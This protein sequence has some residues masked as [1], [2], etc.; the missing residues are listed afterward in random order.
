MTAIHQQTF[1]SGLVRVRELEH[2]VQ[3][4]R[5]Y[6][7]AEARLLERGAHIDRVVLDREL[8]S[9]YQRWL[10]ERDKEH[11]DYDGHPIG[12]PM[13]FAS[14]LTNTTCRTSMTRFI[15]RTSA[16]SIRSRMAAGIG[17]TSRSPRSTL[18]APTAPVSRGR[19]SP[20]IGA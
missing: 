13:R 2:D 3:I 17:K 11:E 4:Y 18:A 9:Q 14:G 8:K 15:S 10:H 7:Q 16:S 19:D 1:H 5:A 12:R 6:E 20:A